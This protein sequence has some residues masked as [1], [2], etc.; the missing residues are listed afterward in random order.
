MGLVNRQVVV[1]T[2]ASHLLVTVLCVGG[3]GIG[4]T[5]AGDAREGP[6]FYP[7]WSSSPWRGTGCVLPCLDGISLVQSF[8]S[9]LVLLACG[10]KVLPYLLI[11][12]NIVLK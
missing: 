2:G 12:K 11:L 3:G 5:P 6:V 9:R 10:S 8:S 1:V 7:P 4:Q